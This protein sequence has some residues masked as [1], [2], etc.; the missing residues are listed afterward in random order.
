MEGVAAALGVDV[1]RHDDAVA[2]FEDHAEYARADLLDGTADLPA[3]ARMLPNPEGVAPGAVLEG[4]DGVSVYVFPGVPGEMK[5][6]FEAVTE[7]FSGTP[8]MRVVIETPAPESSLLGHFED[9]RERFSVAIGSYPGENVR[10]K[11]EGEDTTEVEA[12]AAW[13]RERVEEA[14]PG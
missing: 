13:L 10:I 8:R 7:E 9:A 6:M 12:A 11:L 4:E 5:A 3:G 14:N 2:W 1:V